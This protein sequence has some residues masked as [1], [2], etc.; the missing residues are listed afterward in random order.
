M[1]VTFESFWSEISRSESNPFELLLK[2]SFEN[3][4][5]AGDTLKLTTLHY[6]YTL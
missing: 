5:G 6:H 2:Q 4:N 3:Q 1:I